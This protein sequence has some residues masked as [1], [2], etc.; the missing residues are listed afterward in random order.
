MPLLTEAVS[1]PQAWPSRVAAGRGIRRVLRAH[2]ADV[3]HL[4]MAE[5][6][7]LAAAEVARELGIPVVFTLAPDPHAVIHALDMTGGLHRGNFGTEDEREHYWFR[8]RLV[9]RLTTDAAHIVLF[10][11]P[12]LQDDMR[13]LLGLD[14]TAQP[15][16]FTVVP[17]GVDLR[18]SA[19]AAAELDRPGLPGPA[20]AELDGLVAALPEHRRGLPLVISV[21]RLHRVKGMATLVE[22]WAGDAE[23]RER[24]NLLI[25]GGDMADPSPDEREQ[26]DLIGEVLAQ[27]PGAAEGVLMPGH[28]PNDVVSVWLAAARTGRPGGNGPAGIYVCSSLKEEFGLA[29]LE[30]LASGLVVVGPSAGGPATYIE[31]GV[32]GVLVD[33]RCPAELAEAMRAA[34]DLAT[35]PDQDERI[36]RAVARVRAD[37]TVQTM[38]ER[39]G[40]IYAGAARTAGR[41]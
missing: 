30:A 19:A 3:L 31:D 37:F 21:G 15:D 41:S 27:C 36:D 22:A 1:A 20:L 28:R 6:G 24:S 14:I 13:D 8:A 40:A 16:R 35:A 34:F 23:L 25:V 12:R 33:T 5:V 18:V 38:A 39:L 9:Q 26:L 32:T 10:P 29:L 2:R 11:R 17:E 4:R 7:S